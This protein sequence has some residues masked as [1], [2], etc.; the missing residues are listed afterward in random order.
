MANWRL[1]PHPEEPGV[2]GIYALGG[3]HQRF[4]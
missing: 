4:D 1:D 2:L 3:G